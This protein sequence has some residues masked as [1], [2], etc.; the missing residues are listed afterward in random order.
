MERAASQLLRALRGSRSQIAFA[1]R[2]GYKRNPICDWENG[3]SYPTAVET[4][5]AAGVA[6]VDVAGAFAAFATLEVPPPEGFDTEAL[7]AW[8]DR[9]R[10]AMPIGEV[11]ERTGVSRFVVSR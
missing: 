6:G 10:G 9:L 4:L 8:L 2:L 3:R 1:R 5:R 11:A 7:A